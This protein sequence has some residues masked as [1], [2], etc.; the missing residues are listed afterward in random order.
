MNTAVTQ[1][2]VNW[3]AIIPFTIHPSRQGGAVGEAVKWPPTG[4]LL[5][6]LV[7]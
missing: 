3:L 5:F 4:T 1:L 7:I 2:A 6:I